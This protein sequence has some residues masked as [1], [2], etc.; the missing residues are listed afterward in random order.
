MAYVAGMP[1]ILN[2]AHAV[3]AD[4]E[5]GARESEQQ[6]YQEGADDGTA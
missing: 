1:F 5:R 4:P 6:A 2:A 3:N